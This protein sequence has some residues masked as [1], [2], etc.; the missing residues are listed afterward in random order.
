MKIWICR[1]SPRSGSRNAWTRIKNVNGT[2]RLNNFWNFF[3]RD[4]NSLLARF[5]T[6]DET[7]LYHSD[8]E[9]KQKSME[10]RHSCSPYPKKIPSAKIRWISSRL[11]FLGSRR[12]PPH[13][14]SSKGP[15]YHREV[16]FIS[17]GAI[18]EHFEANAQ[19]AGRSPRGSC[20]CTTMLRV[21]GHLQPGRN[22][23]TWASSILNTSLFSG[24]GPVGLPPV[25]WTKNTIERSPF[26]VR[27]GDHCCRGDLMDGQ[28]SDFFLSGLQTSEQRVKYCIELRGEY[29]E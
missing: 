28:T 23:P 22:W 16:L 17:T 25:P 18:E 13:W 12:H 1:S 14:L 4:P 27:H 8:P 5:V 7:W 24:S 21:P 15:N 29:V 11:D 2:S 3:R 26:F 19:A 9:T 10:W 6:M 20:S